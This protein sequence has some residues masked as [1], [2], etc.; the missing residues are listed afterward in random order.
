MSGVSR[1]AVS[2]WFKAGERVNIKTDSLEKLVNALGIDPA[3]L[4][5]PLPLLKKE[6]LDI[7]RTKLL[8]DRLYSSLDDFFIA[9]IRWDKRAIAR[10]VQA[11]GLYTSAQAFGKRIWDLYPTIKKFVHPARRKELDLIWK[12]KKEIMLK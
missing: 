7:Y 12:I 4:L 8:W 10:F 1:Q 5:N 9:I 11:F 2:L 6:N 3:F